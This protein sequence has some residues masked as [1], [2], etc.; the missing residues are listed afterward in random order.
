MDH[1]ARYSFS[2]SHVD[3]IGY[4][5]NGAFV[6]VDVDWMVFINLFDLLSAVQQWL[7]STDDAL[8]YRVLDLGCGTRRSARF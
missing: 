1:P 5:A 8:W 3:M 6:Y 2:S 4:H 7:I